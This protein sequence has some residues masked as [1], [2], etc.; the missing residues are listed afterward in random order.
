MYCI[1]TQ[2]KAPKPAKETKVKDPNAPK[3]GSSAWNFYQSAM[4]S[5]VKAANPNVEAK[6]IQKL[7]SDNFKALSA[8]ERA[9]YDAK[10]AA[11]K[12]RYQKEMAEYSSKVGGDASSTPKKAAT[13]SSSSSSKSPKKADVTKGMDII[14][15]LKKQAANPPTSASSSSPKVDNNGEAKKPSSASKKRKQPTVK[16]MAGLLNGFMNIKKQ[17]Q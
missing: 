6:E 8:E 5:V 17:K 1:N 4:R 2:K 3:R 16:S 7:L 9:P 11:D 13:P 14:A 15:S 10:A 12:E